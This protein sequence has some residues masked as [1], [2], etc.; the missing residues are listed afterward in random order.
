M[1]EAKDNIEREVTQKLLDSLNVEQQKKENIAKLKSIGGVE[2]LIKL[3]GVVLNEGMDA[4][5][6]VRLR[7]KF[8]SNTF[9]ESPF[10]SFLQLFLGALSDSTLIILMIS[11][12]VSIIL[13]MVT[14]HENGWI[15][16]TSILIAVFLVSTITAT[17]D[18]SKQLQFRSLENSSAK[19]E[20]CSVLRNGNKMRINPQDIVVGDIII[21]HA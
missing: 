13:Q 21:M 12:V 14:K 3:I 1:E 19:D 17:N 16:G 5:G 9:P 15:E 7:E 11:A 2:A 10:E 4:E 18:Y 6:V 20:R 8:G